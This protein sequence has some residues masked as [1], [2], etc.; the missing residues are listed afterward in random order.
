MPRR[1]SLLTV[2]RELVQEEVR[3][4]TDGLLGTLRPKRL[5]KNGRRRRHQGPARPLRF[6]DQAAKPV[7]ADAADGSCLAPPDSWRRA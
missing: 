5:S 2:I 1:K 6:K 3:K 7:A 4:A